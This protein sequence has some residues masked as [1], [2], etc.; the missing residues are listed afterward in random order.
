VFH[1][2]HHKTGT[3]WLQKGLFIDHPS[4]CLLNNPSQPWNCPFVKVIVG[5]SERGYTNQLAHDGLQELIARGGYCY[6]KQSD[7]VAVISAERLS[8]HPLSGGVDS[9]IIAKRLHAVCPDAKI[10]I[11]V[12]HQRSM[13][14]SLYVQ[15]VKEGFIGSFDT[16]ISANSWKRPFFNLLYIE[17]HH[18]VAKYQQLFGA[19][20][21]MVMLFE[22][23]CANDTRFVHNICD[24]LQVPHVLPSNLGLPE[25]VS[26]NLNLTA[27]F[28]RN[29]TLGSEFNLHPLPLDIQ[30]K[31][32][33]YILSSL[34]LEIPSIDL[35]LIDFNRFDY[36]NNILFDMIKMPNQYKGLNSER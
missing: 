5:S 6:A 16:F 30:S 33:D 34:G 7:N 8:G 15:M 24:F 21:V 36:S 17:Y 1:V 19:E 35:S 11:G 23:L 26:G 3:T 22:D 2:G 20:N 27:L 32:L 29:L 31:Q 12:R 13:L 4:I 25:N 10:M 28:R 18:I 9:F 14:A